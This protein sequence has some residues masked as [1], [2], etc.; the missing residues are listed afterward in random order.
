MRKVNYI[1]VLVSLFLSTTFVSC[2]KDT[3]YEDGKIGTKE[4]DNYFVEV[5]LTTGNSNVVSRSYDASDKDITISLIPV[6]L[7]TK[8][9]KD[10]TV[11]FAVLD[12]TSSS[13]LKSY[14]E[15][16]GYVVAD[17]NKFKIQNSELKVTIPKGSSTGY[18][19]VKFTPSAFIGQTYIFGIQI[20]SITDTK[21]IVSNLD[22]GF[23]KFGIKNM[24]DGQ[25]TN[26]GT[27]EDKVNPALTA[28]YPLVVNLITQDGSSVAYFDA[29]IYGDYYHAIKNGSSYSA[30]G[31]FAP[32]FK[33]DSNNKVVA[34]VNYY[35]Q[36]AANGRKAELDTTTPGVV[37]KYDPTT[38][39]LKVTY[40]MI[41]N[42]TYRTHFDET[43]TYIGPR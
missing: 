6:N 18:V 11:T 33:F 27:M 15:D 1:F 31:S 28:A 9:D 2:L 36:P 21:Y 26:T 22:K 14:V 17:V 37:N 13:Q 29:D 12:T 41:Q 8:A 5:H 4:G 10:V 32:I 24:Y 43:F 19:K 7:T 35:G 30:Y 39:T 23:V 42:G 25:Y 34:V 38:K 20:K 3:D 16:D 40:W